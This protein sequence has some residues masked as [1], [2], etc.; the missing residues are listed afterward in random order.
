MN[1][2]FDIMTVGVIG[3]SILIAVKKGLARSIIE[4]AGFLVSL[5]I[6]AMLSSPVGEWLYIIAVKPI[7]VD[8][9]S[10][11]IGNLINNNAVAA[12][13]STDVNKIFD[14]V[15]QQLLDLSKQF[16]VSLDSVRPVAISKVSEGSAA[17]TKAIVDS[18]VT[19]LA[20][21]IS[22]V[23]AFILVFIVCLILVKVIANLLDG[24]LNLPVLGLFNK[25]GGAVF[26]VI[27][28]VLIVCLLG[29]ILTLLLPFIA[30]QQKSVDIINNTVTYKY[31]NQINP[32]SNY[33]VTKIGKD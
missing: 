7:F 9:A 24:V 5:F 15:P 13:N 30:P 28:G 19:P 11:R 22:E 3:F 8:F 33:F 1:A 23:I 10:K 27:R 21:K 4:F 32:I 26:G 17:V 18:I 16:G 2:V 25:V 14:N 6:A 29:T 12:I 20:T 31:V